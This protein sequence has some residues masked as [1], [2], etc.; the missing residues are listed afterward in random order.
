MMN[1]VQNRKIQTNESTEAK[2]R[3]TQQQQRLTSCVRHYSDHPAVSYAPPS[4]V[5][6]AATFTNLLNCKIN[7]YCRHCTLG[8]TCVPYD[9]Y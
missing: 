5:V 7:L 1:I 9:S 8:P 4:Q 3:N 6:K 2:V